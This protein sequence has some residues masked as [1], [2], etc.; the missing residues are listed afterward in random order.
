MKILFVC[1][2]NICRSPTAEAVFRKVFTDRGIPCEVD[3]AATSAFHIGD[4]SDPRSIQ[5]A[6]LRGYKMTHLGRQLNTQDFK[7]FDLILGMDNSNIENILKVCPPEHKSKVKLLTAYATNSEYKLVPDPY[8][9]QAE[10]FERVLD[11][12]ENC[13]PRLI[14]THFHQKPLET[15]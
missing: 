4:P 8:Y 1:L 2:G 13:V 5:H 6:E 15:K 12:I 10:D 11:I 3:S 7:N 9:G 14:E